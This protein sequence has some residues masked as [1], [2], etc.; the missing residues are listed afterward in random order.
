[1]RSVLSKMLDAE[2]QD[3]TRPWWDAMKDS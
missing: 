3:S 2:V 1:V